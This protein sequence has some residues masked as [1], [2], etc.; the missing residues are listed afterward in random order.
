M[1]AGALSSLRPC[2]QHFSWVYP[3]IK[4]FTAAVL[5]GIGNIQSYAGGMFIGLF[6]SIGPSLFLDGLGI[7]ASIN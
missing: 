7:K 4:A 6:E 2:Q 3:G 5:G 1:A